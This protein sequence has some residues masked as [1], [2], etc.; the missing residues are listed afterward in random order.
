MGA[1]DNAICETEYAPLIGK[2]SLPAPLKFR[3]HD[4]STR[5]IQ[6]CDTS[7]GDVRPSPHNAVKLQIPRCTESQSDYEANLE[8]KY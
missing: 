1:R 4:L 2:P 3:M 6:G 7:R 8:H 5:D